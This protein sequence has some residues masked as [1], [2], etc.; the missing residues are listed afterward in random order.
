MIP[1]KSNT[2]K[3]CDNIS[4]NCVIWQGPDDVVAKLAEQLC[5]CCGLTGENKSSKSSSSID[6]RTVNQLCLETD[7]GKANNIQTLL[8]NIVDKLCTC[9]AS[10]KSA[11]DV[12]SCSILLPDCLRENARKYLNTTDSVSTMV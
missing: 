1:N 9:C 10:T 7:Y 12:C 8:T 5:E 4:S 11:T 6:I 3:G 2:T